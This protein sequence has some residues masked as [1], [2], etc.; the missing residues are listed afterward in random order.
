MA[1]KHDAEHDQLTRVGAESRCRTHAA[2]MIVGHACLP[3]TPDDAA[4]T[5]S[6][7]PNRRPQRDSRPPSSVAPQAEAAY[8]KVARVSGNRSVPASCSRATNYPSSPPSAST[9]KSATPS[10]APPCS[11]SRQKGRSTAGRARAPTW[12]THFPSSPHTDPADCICCGYR[13]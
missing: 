4:G 10:S 3:P 9:T 8:R 13:S 7:F 6:F 1:P 12:R 2:S 5:R 11:S